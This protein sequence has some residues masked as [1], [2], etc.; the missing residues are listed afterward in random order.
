[1]CPQQTQPGFTHWGSFAEYI[2][3]HA[4]D[5][6]LVAVSDAISDAAAA[7]LGCRYAEHA[8]CVLEPPSSRVSG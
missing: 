8:R 4:A 6:N 5:A 1:M 3:L 2:A 7:G